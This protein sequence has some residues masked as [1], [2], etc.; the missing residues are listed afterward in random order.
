MHIPQHQV[1]PT[2]WRADWYG[3]GASFVGLGEQADNEARRLGP[4]GGQG[5]TGRRAAD[6]YPMPALFACLVVE[7]RTTGESGARPCPRSV[8]D[9]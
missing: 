7:V 1:Y 5:P 6:K 3:V 4:E 2:V 9:P 8:A